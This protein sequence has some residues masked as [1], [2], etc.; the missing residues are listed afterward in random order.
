MNR[1]ALVGLLIPGVLTTGCWSGS[2]PAG[3]GEGGGGPSSTGIGGGVSGSGIATTGGT[4]GSDGTGGEAPAPAIDAGIPGCA[5]LFVEPDGLCRPTLAKCPKG[6]IPWF[7]QGCAP[8]GIE[9]CASEFL[10]A[11]G[12]CH[13]AISKCP[14]GTLPVPTEGCVPID[15]P[16]GCGAAPWGAIADGASTIWVDPSYKGDANDGSKQSP[17]TTLAA[18]LALVPEGGRVALAAGNYGEAVIVKQSVEI[19]GRCP[20]LVKITGEG[21][22]GGSTA[23]VGID[24]T[25][26]G[27]TLRNLKIGGGGQGIAVDGSGPAKVIV[28]G[29]WVKNAREIALV[30][31]GPGASVEVKH[32]F[33]QATLASDQ[34]TLGRGVVALAGATVV[35]DASVV[36]DNLTAGIGA[37]DAGSHLTFTNG[38]IEGTW[39]RASDGLLGVGALVDSGATAT[40]GG[41]AIVANRSAGALIRGSGSVLDVK[42]SVL[43]KTLA[44]EADQSLGVGLRA[45]SKAT[46]TIEASAILDTLLHGVASFDQGTSVTLDQTLVAGTTPQLSDGGGGDGVHAEN[47]GA[48]QF[49]HSA[50]TGNSHAG[51]SAQ[52]PGTAIH[53]AS[54]LVQA[55][56]SGHAGGGILAYAGSKATIDSSALVG[57]VGEGL[58]LHPGAEAIVTRSLLAGTVADAAGNNGVGILSL[59]ANFF[60]IDASLLLANRGA[61]VLARGQLVMSG[62][63]VRGVTLG[64][65]A[66]DALSPVD[67]IGDGLLVVPGVDPAAQIAIRTSLF[68]GCERAGILVASSGGAIAGSEATKNRF[69][70]VLQGAPTPA[71]AADNVFAGNTEKDRLDGAML[72]VP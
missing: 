30:A 50:A 2:S 63:M 60:Q 23:T 47:G 16:A 40:V 48:I 21:A 55:N 43:E 64:R 65:I 53:L 57:N 44:Q 61:G 46:A 18:A 69:G 34:G 5:A 52:T 71:V 35:V 3:G 13:V 29:V 49:T 27:V 67:G 42:A 38:L 72:P 15:G 11:D 59:D 24:P 62:S 1:I 20:S 41:S 68:Q 10:E 8:V 6:S 22:F 19:V 7:D 51:V 32:S 26:A 12:V 14:S 66:V 28:D 9:G 31:T 70:L 37:S 54:S 58:F 56:G 39:G 45:E 33:F 4:T 36:L 25:P 17:V